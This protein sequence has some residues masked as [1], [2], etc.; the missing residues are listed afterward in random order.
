MGGVSQAL[1]K[2]TSSPASSKMESS[3]SLHSIIGAQMHLPWTGISLNVLCN[4]LHLG[5]ELGTARKLFAN[6]RGVGLSQEAQKH[7]P[8]GRKEPGT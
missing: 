4:L 8:K 6:L 5:A 3:W 1:P 7:R 2:G